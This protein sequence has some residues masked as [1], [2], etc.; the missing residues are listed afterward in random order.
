MAVL[1]EPVGRT[2]LRYLLLSPVV[3]TLVSQ[4]TSSSSCKAY[5]SIY[6][7]RSHKV[8]HML[9]L[10]LQIASTVSRSGNERTG[11]CL[12]CSPSPGCCVHCNHVAVAISRMRVLYTCISNFKGSNAVNSFPSLN[13]YRNSP[14]FE[15]QGQAFCWL[16]T[17]RSFEGA[18]RH[19]V[20]MQRSCECNLSYLAA[21][22][23]DLLVDDRHGGS[24]S[25]QKFL[26]A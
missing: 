14:S 25:R 15:A 4:Y 8:S 13:H 3:H 2:G 17:C 19:A 23:I 16:K 12:Y 6:V 7:F 10:H 21:I 20:R 18:C 11:P 24:H 9:I 26:P 5:H 1:L 22:Q